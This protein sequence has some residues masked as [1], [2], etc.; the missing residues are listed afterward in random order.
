MT[1]AGQ[2]RGQVAHDLGLARLRDL[3]DEAGDDVADQRLVRARGTRREPP[4]DEVAAPAV[5]RVVE[6]DDR[7]VGRDVRPVAARV[8]PRRRVL[9]DLDDVVVARDAPELVDLVAVHR[10]VGTQVRVR[11]LGVARVEVAVEQ[12]E[13]AGV[14]VGGEIH[15]G[16][17]SV[18]PTEGA[19]APVEGDRMPDGDEGSRLGSPATGVVVTGAASGIGRA[20]ARALAAIGRPVAVWDVDGDGAAST[21][22]AIG[23]DFGVAT[24]SVAL[25]VQDRAAIAAAV[26][27]TVARVGIRRRARA[28]GR[29]RASRARGRGRR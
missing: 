24:H 9:L 26:D 13:A 25:D 4:R 10:P 2:R 6:P 7:R 17:S 1:F 29:H 27:P 5:E 22:S 19:A 12:V 23:A 16:L 15:R 21:A 14:D 11:G 3:V 8:A 20:C 18:P 28:R